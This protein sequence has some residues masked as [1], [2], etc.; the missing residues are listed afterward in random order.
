MTAETLTHLERRKIEAR[1]LIPMV[2]AFQRA[3]GAERANAVAR[4]V[5]LDWSR[6]DGTRWAV[7]FGND[8]A[9]LEEVWKLWAGG[10]NRTRRSASTSRVAAT[11]SSFGRSALRSLVF[12]FAAIATSPWSRGS[13]R[14]CRCRARRPSCRAPTIAISATSGRK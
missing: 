5:F 6:T 4:E 1:V 13:T 12:C 3:V 7:R 8:F 14:A 11:P 10:G 2:Q 9:G